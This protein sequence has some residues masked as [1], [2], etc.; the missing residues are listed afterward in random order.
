MKVDVPGK[1]SIFLRGKTMNKIEIEAKVENLTQVLS[2]VDEVLEQMGC[3]MKEQMKIDLAVEEIYVNIAS[4]AYGEKTGMAEICLDYADSSEK[5]KWIRITLSDSGIPYDP[6]KK[7]DPDVTLSAEEGV[8]GGLG[9]FMVK[10][11]MDD[12]V[13]KYEDGFNILTLVKDIS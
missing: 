5:G 2:F 12:M 7:P 9:I 4:Y 6:L 10:N 13:Y 8:P 1:G 11:T 3:S